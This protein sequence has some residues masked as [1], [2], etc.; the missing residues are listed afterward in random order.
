MENRGE[1]FL[2]VSVAWGDIQVLRAYELFTRKWIC[3]DLEECFLNQLFERGRGSPHPFDE[4]VPQ[5]SAVAGVWPKLG[6]QSRPLTCE[7]QSLEPLLA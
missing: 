5:M 2:E 6:A 4:F 7:A 1:D 3:G